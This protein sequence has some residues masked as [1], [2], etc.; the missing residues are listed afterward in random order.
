MSTLSSDAKTPCFVCRWCG[1]KDGYYQN[2]T[3]YGISKTIRIVYDK[4]HKLISDPQKDSEY[5][6]RLSKKAYC[7][8]CDSY[9][10]KVVD[11]KKGVQRY[12]KY[13]SK[14]VGGSQDAN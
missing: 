7:C 12:Y 5:Y 2:A 10:G 6:Y 14:R 9:V 4:N 3:N 1:S 8:H 11:V 13:K